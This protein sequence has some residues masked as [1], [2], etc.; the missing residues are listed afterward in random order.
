MNTNNGWDRF[1]NFNKTLHQLEVKG[2]LL[3]IASLKYYQ[4]C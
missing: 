2:Q 1:V 3:L 4:C